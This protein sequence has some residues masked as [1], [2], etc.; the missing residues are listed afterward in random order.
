MAEKRVERGLTSIPA[1]DPAE[2]PR[3]I[4][5][6]TGTQQVESRARPVMFPRPGSS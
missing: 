3:L 2:C 4:D 1:T 5:A 6:D